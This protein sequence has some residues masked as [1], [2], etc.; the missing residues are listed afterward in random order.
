MTVPRARVGYFPSSLSVFPA[1]A[2]VGQV[3]Q[4]GRHRVAASTGLQLTDRDL[5]MLRDLG[6]FGVLTAAQLARRYY[7]D[8]T[9]PETC[10]NR[11]LRLRQAGYLERVVI[12]NGVEHAY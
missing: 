1:P 12:A 11:L 3:G 7:P 2:G 6:R 9:T 8:S 10:R 4:R 5:A